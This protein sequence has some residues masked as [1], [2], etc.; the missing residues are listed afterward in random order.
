M[1]NTTDTPRPMIGVHV[2]EELD[3]AARR[4]RRLIDRYVR[5]WAAGKRVD[6]NR[7]V[8]KLIKHS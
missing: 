1:P 4:R 7:L 8:R 3:R 2:A 6:T 5:R